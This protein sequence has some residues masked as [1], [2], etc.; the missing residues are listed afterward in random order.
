MFHFSRLTKNINSPSLDLHSL[1]S[2]IFCSKDM[3]YYLG[4]FDKKLSFHQHIHYYEQS[5]VY[6]QEYENV[7]QFYK[8]IISNIQT[9]TLQNVYP[10]Y[11]FIQIS[12]LVFQKSTTLSAAQ[13]IE[14]NAEKSSFMNHRSILHLTDMRSRSYNWPHFYL[15]PP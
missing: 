10:S 9:T 8:R 14:K 13:G 5:P 7:G 4:F 1:G 2:P 15:F 3:W 12:A 11:Y 6:D